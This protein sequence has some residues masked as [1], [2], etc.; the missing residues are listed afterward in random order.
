[1]DRAAAWCYTLNNYT[2]EESEALWKEGTYQIQGYEKGSEGTPHIQGYI[3]FKNAKRLST[4]KKINP[5]IHWEI[6]RGNQKAAIQY[7]KKSDCQHSRFH[8][9]IMEIR[10]TKTR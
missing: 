10:E 2:E 1:M 8:S 7:C 4:L 5:R 3:E 6:R 9:T